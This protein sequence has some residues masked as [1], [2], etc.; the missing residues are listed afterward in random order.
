M[1][2]ATTGTT[3]ISSFTAIVAATTVDTISLSAATITAGT[4]DRILSRTALAAA[5]IDSIS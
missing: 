3:C 5:A 2:T 4:T 1:L